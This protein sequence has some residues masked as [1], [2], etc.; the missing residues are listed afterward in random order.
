MHGFIY[1]VGETVVFYGVIF[2]VLVVS[3]TICEEIKNYKY[4]KEEK[5]RRKKT[6][7]NSETNEKIKINW[8]ELEEKN[9]Q[10][11]KEKNKTVNTLTDEE[12]E[13][14]ENITEENGKIDKKDVEEVTEYFFKHALYKNFCIEL[15]EYILKGK[16]ERKIID[17]EEWDESFFDI[18]IF[19]DNR[20]DDVARIKRFLTQKGILKS[21]E[22]IKRNEKYIFYTTENLHIILE[23]IY[24]ENKKVEKIKIFLEENNISFEELYYSKLNKKIYF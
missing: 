3:A 12:I 6:E 24:I 9:I 8:E 23:I 18:N 16:I 15:K 5:K 22:E 13:E 17:N 14:I 11:V 7:A 4:N 19:F 20:C 1:S 10:R 21:V 2:I